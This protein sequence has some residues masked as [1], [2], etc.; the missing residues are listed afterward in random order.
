MKPVLKLVLRLDPIVLAVPIEGLLRARSC[1]GIIVALSLIPRED[2]GQAPEL[3]LFSL[4]QWMS[5]FR[6]FSKHS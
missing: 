4:T 5:S 1:R 3:Y 6:M 2:K